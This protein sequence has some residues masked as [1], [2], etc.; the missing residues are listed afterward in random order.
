MPAPP[1]QHYILMR[2][3]HR[4]SDGSTAEQYRWTATNPPIGTPRTGGHRRVG[5]K[6][7]RES[8]YGDMLRVPSEKASIDA[9]GAGF[10]KSDFAQ[11]RSGL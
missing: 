11:H 4:H 2:A 3:Q 1:G 5:T 10:S 7:H 8:A 9:T 6:G